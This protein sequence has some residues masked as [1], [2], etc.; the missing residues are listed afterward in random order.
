MYLSSLI[1]ALPPLLVF[2]LLSGLVDAR[3]RSLAQQQ[4]L[5]S[6]LAE[7]PLHT[8]ALLAG[9]AATPM[10]AMPTVALKSRVMNRDTIVTQDESVDTERVREALA[11]RLKQ[12][13]LR[14]LRI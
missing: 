10:P 3:I 11:E 12:I 1:R 7:K 8:T 5:A 4:R 2:W 14:E 13:E 6:I 9:A